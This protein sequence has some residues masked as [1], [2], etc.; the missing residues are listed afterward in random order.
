MTGS[1]WRQGRSR[2]TSFLFSRA[3]EFGQRMLWVSSL[4]TKPLSVFSYASWAL[5]KTTCGAGWWERSV[6]LWR[7]ML[8]ST[9]RHLLLKNWTGLWAAWT[10]KRLVR[11][12]NSYIFPYTPCKDILF[13]P[14]RNKPSQVTQLIQSDCK[15]CSC[16]LLASYSS[17]SFSESV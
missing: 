12:P 5:L 6:A 9:G 15:K 1:T 2:K 7:R 17:S 4:A 3:A 10:L 14:S 8:E 11:R 16:Y 13:V